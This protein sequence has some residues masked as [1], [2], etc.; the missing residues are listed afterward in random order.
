VENISR[1]TFLSTLEL[2]EWTLRESGLSPWQAQ[3]SVQ[4]FK[5][6]DEQ[7]LARQHAVYHDETQL[8]QTTRESTQEMQSLLESDRE[9]A[10]ELDGEVV[11][12]PSDVR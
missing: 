2:A 7:V 12:S 10:G 4:R 5:R 1:E 9:D 6:H 11:F 3:Q 8:I